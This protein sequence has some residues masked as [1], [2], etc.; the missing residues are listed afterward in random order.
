MQVLL[1]IFFDRSG[2]KLHSSNLKE[3]KP[4][5]SIFST[6]CPLPVK[7][8]KSMFRVTNCFA[9]PDLVKVSSNSF[10]YFQ[11]LQPLQN[12]V[13]QCYTGFVS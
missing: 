8:N 1:R 3:L 10:F 13:L 2:E 6:G 9:P 12:D 7:P 5:L 4:F 11:F